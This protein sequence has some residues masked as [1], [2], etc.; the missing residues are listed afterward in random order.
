MP[1]DT[2]LPHALGPAVIHQLPTALREDYLQAFAGALHTV[3]LSAACVVVLAF[4]L[5]WLL[6]DH[7][8]RKH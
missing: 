1:P 3:Y 4:A 5:T 2:E 8:L 7:P 6:K